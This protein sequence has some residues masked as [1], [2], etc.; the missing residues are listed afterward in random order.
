MD[1]SEK[2]VLM[3]QKF[4]QVTL[5]SCSPAA[6]WPC[7]D[8]SHPHPAPSPTP[9]SFHLTYP[10]PRPSVIPLSLGKIEFKGEGGV[11]VGLRLREN[12]LV[13]QRVKDVILLLQQ[14]ICTR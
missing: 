6:R 7:D 3:L 4:L 2:K 10:S 8:S 5:W 9:F 12:L 11:K 14:H 13:Y 1:W